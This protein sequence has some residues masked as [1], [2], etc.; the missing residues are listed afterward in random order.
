[1]NRQPTLSGER[2]ELRP[3][4]ESDREALFAVASDPL[5]WEQHP[6]PDR[7]KPEVFGP[8]F[9]EALAK[10]GAL[11]AIDRPT[12]RIAGGSQYRPTPHDSDA[13]EIGW[14]Y[15]AREYWGSG[16]NRE[17]K[18]LMLRHALESV[19]RVLFRVGDANWRSRKAMEKIGGKLTD[20]TETGEY[21]GKPLRHVVYEITRDSFATGPLG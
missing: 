14:T 17:M 4:R 19:P 15:L 16:F 8:F 12:G 1:M 7:W 18:R 2:V 13:V 3:L 5:V 20:I 9:D 10:G 21:R 6:V 11:V